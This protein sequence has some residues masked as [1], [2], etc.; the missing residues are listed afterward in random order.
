M[1]HQKKSPRILRRH[2]SN[3]TQLPRRRGARGAEL[4]QELADGDVELG[5]ATRQRLADRTG[6]F[7]VDRA[8]VALHVG[9]VVRSDLHAR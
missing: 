4:F 5:V 1:P 9:A 8:R 2:Y 7:D 3:R 6:H